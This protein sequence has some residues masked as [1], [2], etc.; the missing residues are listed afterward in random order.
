MA[1][2]NSPPPPPLNCEGSKTRDFRPGILPRASRA[3]TISS[4]AVRSRSAAGFSTETKTALLTAP[5]PSGPETPTPAK[6][7]FTS[8]C[9]SIHFSAWVSRS[10]VPCRVVPGGVSIRAKMRPSSDGGK[11]SNPS[12]E[13]KPIPIANESTAI[14]STMVRCASAQPRTPS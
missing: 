13:P 2:S 1:N 10:S 8:G 9:A 3:A 11:N 6:R 5:G 14:P 4:W 7:P 12:R